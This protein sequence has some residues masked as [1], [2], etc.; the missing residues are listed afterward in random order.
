M[1][2]IIETWDK[3]GQHAVRQSARPA[4]LAFPEVRKVLLLARGGRGLSRPQEFLAI[5]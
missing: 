1:P 2:Y 3:P 5:A 4:H